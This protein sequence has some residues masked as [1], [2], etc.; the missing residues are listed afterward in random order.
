MRAHVFVCVCPRVHDL[1]CAAP[2]V[3]KSTSLSSHIHGLPSETYTPLNAC[4]SGWFSRTAC[5]VA[6]CCLLVFLA[7]LPGNYTPK[8]AFA[9]QPCEP[10]E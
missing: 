1:C 9:S 4:S 8:C 2:T 10:P 5:T 7:R 3:A 6:E